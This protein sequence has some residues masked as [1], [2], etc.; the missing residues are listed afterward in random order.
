M[1][2]SLIRSWFEE[3]HGVLTAKELNNLG[4]SYYSIRRLLKENIIEKVKRGIYALSD[5]VEEYGLIMKLVPT[6]IW[7]L[8]SAAF[9]YNYTTHIPSRHHLA[10]YNKDNYNLPEFPPIKL[11]YWMKAQYEL[12]QE[13]KDYNGLTIRIYNREKTVCDYLKFRN[14]LEKSEVKEVLNEYL[15]DPRRDMVTLKRYSH[16]LK[17][18]TVLDQYLEVLL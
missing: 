3:N 7:C 2:I 18:S 15:K 13:E 12:G 5:S 9:Q 10:V 11:Y 6:G 1:N 14:K 8:Q 17:I 16:E 4:I